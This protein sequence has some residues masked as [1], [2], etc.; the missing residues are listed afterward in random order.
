MLII[1]QVSPKFRGSMLSIS[2]N[3]LISLV[4]WGCI[5]Q[6]ILVDLPRTRIAM[7]EG[8]GD[9]EFTQPKQCGLCFIGW[10]LGL[11][12]P[13]PSTRDGV[14]KQQK[15]IFSQFWR[16]EVQG[17]GTSGLVLV[18]ALFLSCTWPPSPSG[19]TWTFLWVCGERALLHFFLFLKGHPV[20][21]DLLNLFHLLYRSSL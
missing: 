5:R 2:Y 4:I 1:P 9:W 3:W 13:Y 6:L 12:R 17:Q 11:L 16:L 19:L 15:F 21:L 8:G 10:C 14:A 7:A 18:R 20:P